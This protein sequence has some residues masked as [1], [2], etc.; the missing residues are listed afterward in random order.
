M[1]LSAFISYIG[2]R[3]VSY[4]VFLWSK[5]A[6]L[7]EFFSYR[8]VYNIS[9]SQ[10]FHP[11]YVM[12]FLPLYFFFLTSYF[13]KVTSKMFM[14]TW[15]NLRQIS[16]IVFISISL[17]NV[18]QIFY[19]EVQECWQYIMWWYKSINTCLPNNPE[20]FWEYQ[21]WQNILKL[22]CFFF[23]VCVLL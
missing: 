22:S 13:N 15:F 8:S 4:F 11:C 7:T 5:Q 14:S 20:T 6:H 9:F 19:K 16:L 3:L 17:T 12:T 18:Q 2:I 1:L 21:G 10:K 23:F